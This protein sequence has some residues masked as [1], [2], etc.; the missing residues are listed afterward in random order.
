MN[1]LLFFVHLPIAVILI[2]PF[3]SALLIQ[4][5]FDSLVHDVNFRL[6]NFCEIAREIFQ[7]DVICLLRI[8]LVSEDFFLDG[9]KL[10]KVLFSEFLLAFFDFV[11]HFVVSGALDDVGEIEREI[12]RCD[13]LP[14]QTDVLP[15]LTKSSA[16]PPSRPGTPTG[17]PVV[18]V[19]TEFGDRF[20]VGRVWNVIWRIE[21]LQRVTKDADVAF[22]R[23]GRVHFEA[24][25]DTEQFLF[26]SGTT[27]LVHLDESFLQGRAQ[28]PHNIVEFVLLLSVD[29][30]VDEEQPAAHLTAFLFG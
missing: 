2:F 23:I 20:P 3:L 13:A 9:C 21:T 1:E 19:L 16:V 8:D 26:L 10:G 17:G 5:A 12:G 4:N 27:H 7:V 14:H 6:N 30:V 22:F 28:A 18:N 24:R 25:E 11:V 29:L 15:E